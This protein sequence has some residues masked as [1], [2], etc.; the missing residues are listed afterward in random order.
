MK[1]YKPILAA[2]GALLTGIGGTVFT[3]QGRVE[4]EAQELY[5]KRVEA[6]VRQEI[7]VKEM[8]KDVQEMSVRLFKV[9]GELAVMRYKAGE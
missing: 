4:K 2:L 5:D 3:Q 9:E 7:A 8:E 6:R 1:D